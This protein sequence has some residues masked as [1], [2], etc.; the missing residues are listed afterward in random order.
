VMTSQAWAR[1][2]DS[3][4]ARD[5]GK[6]EEGKEE[7]KDDGSPFKEWDKVL[8][9]AESTK[10]LFTVYRKHDEKYLEIAPEQLDRP[11]LMVSSLSSGLGK[12]FLLGG[13]PLDTDLWMFHRA[14]NRIQVKIR[15]NRFRGSTGQPVE[16]AVALSYGDSVLASA[17]IVSIEKETK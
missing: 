11:F 12:G 17:K 4:P 10:G 16:K 2:K 15:N 8:K 9:D 13:M 7:K 6:K 1:K 14:G 3:A 5:D